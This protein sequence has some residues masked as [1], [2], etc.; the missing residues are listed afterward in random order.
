DRPS[1]FSGN[2]HPVETITWSRSRRCCRR[3]R[4]LLGGVFRLPTEAEWEYACRAGTYSLFH[5]G[6]DEEALK[7]AGWYVENTEEGTSPVGQLTPNSWGLYD[8]HGNVYEWCSAPCRTF[9]REGVT[10]PVGTETASHCIRGGYWGRPFL[11]C[12]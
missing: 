9:S 12:R 11:S 4:D 3:L 5:S 7:R 6:N 2:N 8:M 1:Y 10:D